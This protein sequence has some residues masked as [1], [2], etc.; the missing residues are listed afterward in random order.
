MLEFI[1]TQE[2][3][4]TIEKEF[5]KVHKYIEKAQNHYEKGIKLL[6]KE[7]QKAAKEP[8]IKKEQITKMLEE[9]VPIKLIAIL[10]GCSTTH[11]YN[12]MKQAQKEPKEKIETTTEEPE[13]INQEEKTEIDEPKHQEENQQ[14]I[15]L[16]D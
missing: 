2:S 15:P 5:N 14:D 6:D 12:T 3:L 10:V 7:I 4:I 8:E 1:T 11:I 9:H 16:E 13:Q